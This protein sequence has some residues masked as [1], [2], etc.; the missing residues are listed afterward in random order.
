MVLI[1]GTSV[2]VFL[3]GAGRDCRSFWPFQ[4]T[5]DEAKPLPGVPSPGSSIRLRLLGDRVQQY[6]GLCLRTCEG[7]NM[8]GATVSRAFEPGVTSSSRSPSPIELVNKEKEMAVA[9]N[10]S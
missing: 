3:S 5:P 10:L 9:G 7:R 1:F 2:K 4:V 8:R 6:T